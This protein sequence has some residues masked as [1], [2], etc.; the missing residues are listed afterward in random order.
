MSAIVEYYGYLLSQGYGEKQLNDFANYAKRANRGEISHNKAYRLARKSGFGGF[1]NMTSQD[2]EN[3]CEKIHNTDE[4]VKSCVDNLL[5]ESSESK[6]SFG[7]WMKTAKG[8]GWI[9]KGLT[10]LSGGDNNQG[11][12]N[13]RNNNNNKYNTP[14]NNTALYIGIGVV[15]LIGI[16]VAIYFARKK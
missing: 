15:A 11:D 2:A 3:Q 14:Q 12:I 9:D 16:G 8:A 5:N 7:D 6:G 4:S 10:L 1:S 13:T